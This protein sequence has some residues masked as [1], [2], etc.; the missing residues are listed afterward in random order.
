MESPQ[1]Q[2][3][4]NFQNLIIITA[5]NSD[6]FRVMTNVT[7]LRYYNW[8]KIRMKL[9]ENQLYETITAYKKFTQNLEADRIMII[10]K[11]DIPAVA[12]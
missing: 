6:K 1:F 7:R 11:A 9:I 4:I 3:N 2:N 8:N 5:M 12:D 10:Y